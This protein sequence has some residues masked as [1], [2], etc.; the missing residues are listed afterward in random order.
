MENR[1][2]TMELV[3]VRDDGGVNQ[4]AAVDSEKQMNSEYILKTVKTNRIY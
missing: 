4:G 1:Q 2:E 3:Q